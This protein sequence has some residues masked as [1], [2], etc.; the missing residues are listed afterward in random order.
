L[1]AAPLRYDE[2]WTPQPYLAKSWDVSE[3]GLTVTLNLVDNAVF[4]DGTP[5]TS[6]D[7][8]FSV[9]TIKAHHPFK[10]MFAPVVSVDTPDAHTAVLNLS[11]PH[12]ALMLAMSGQLMA[13]IPK[14]IY[15]DGQDPKTH[16]RNT[17]N[18]VGSG[19]FKLVE[20]K[21][22]EHVILER[23]DDFFIEGRP[24][25]DKV[26]M[27]I[28]TDPAARA[29]AYENGEVHM[30]AFESLPRI[31]NRL[32][33]V[34]S[35]T[36]TDEGYG[37]IGPLDWLAMNTTKGPLADVN[38]RK[39]IAY[40]VDK[41]FIHKALMQGTASDSKTGIHPDS[42]FY[43]ANVEGYDLDLDKSRA[44]LDA[45]GYPMQ[46]D[47]RFSLT[48][49]F[50]WP[51]VKP[52]VE[53]VKAALK[54]V[55]I[56]VEVRASA[57][58]PTWAARMGEMDFDMSWDTVFNWGDPVIGVHRTYSSDNIAKGVWSNT[59]GY[60]NARVDELIAMAAVETDPAKRSALYAEFQEI[61]ADEVPVYHTNTLPYHT[62][63]NDN[64]GNPP[65][66]IW[67]TSTPID[68]TYLK[69]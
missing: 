15:G 21:S 3:D 50:G 37:G 41:N 5:I 56:D 2:D 12:P 1:F 19:P 31:I 51:G 42:P 47:S 29:I 7:V 20:Y 23:F 67:G 55:G 14:H 59:Q 45:A 68:M 61:I 52:Q 48:I 16:P 11:K 36:V 22:G 9:D 49:D 44:L 40:A 4:H 34:D 46:G 53:Y 13:I 35:L 28:I 69:K 33:K 43:N 57:D 17:E 39:A 63:Y 38:V 30:G 62:V 25:L 54:K 58:F 27:R 60:S 64:V 24:Y 10:S 65:L 26:V 18:V 6:E 32:K 8:A 66:G